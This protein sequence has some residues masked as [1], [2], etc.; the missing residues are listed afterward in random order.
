[1]TR[2]RSILRALVLIVA[3]ALF[4]VPVV[5][6]AAPDGP[7]PNQRIDLKVLLLTP[8]ATDG[9]FSAW[10]ETLGKLGVPY[11]T[12][13]ASTSA[14]ITDGTLADYNA[15]RAFYQAVIFASSG[16]ALSANERTA[17]DKL[18]TTFGV[19][20][21]SDNTNPD[22]GHGA[23][24][25]ATGGTIPLGSTVNGSLSAAGQTVFPYLKG[26]VPLTGEMFAASGTPTP[27][28]TSLVNAPAGAPYEGGSFMGIWKRPNGTEQLVDGIPGNG[29]QTHYQLM[30]FGML[31]WA[32]RGV[33]LGYWRNYFEVQVDDLFLGDDAWDTTTH[34]NNYDPATASRM[35]AADLAKAL[36]WSQANNFRFDFAYNAGG[37]AQFEGDNGTGSDALWNAFREQRG[38]PQRLRIHQPHLRPRLPGL[39]ERQ[40]HHGRDQPEHHGRSRHR[41]PGERERAHHGRALGPREHAARQPRRARS[42]DLRHPRPRPAR[43]HDPGRHLLLRRDGQQRPRPDAFPGVTRAHRGRPRAVRPGDG[44][45]DLQGHDLRPLPQPDADRAVDARRSGDRRRAAR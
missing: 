19:R 30:R 24:A 4:A 23:T 15:N 7:T 33:Y 31:N 14:V 18:E 2:R 6:L 11:D 40:L 35:T 38:L 5:A 32:T 39:L 29:Q 26:G 13:D 36:V 8:T 20:E 42:A 37:H 25:P 12:Y 3:V 45:D 17:V 10:K 21:I 22:A 28:F 27:A 9:V 1:M 44:V 34:S 16:V 41:T 43:R